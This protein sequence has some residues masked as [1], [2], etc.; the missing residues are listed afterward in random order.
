MVNFEI[1]RMFDKFYFNHLFNVGI[2]D[3]N[4]FTAK[5]KLNIFNL[6]NLTLNLK[7]YSIYI[8]LLKVLNK[9][10]N[11]HCQFVNVEFG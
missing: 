7:I 4:L 5:K 1:L 8:L 10:N 9:I 3:F 6:K 2:I 11:L